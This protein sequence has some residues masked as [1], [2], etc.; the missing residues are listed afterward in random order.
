MTRKIK[1]LIAVLFFLLAAYIL[2]WFKIFDIIQPSLQQSTFNRPSPP[3]QLESE[4]VSILEIDF[5]DGEKLSL[6]Y[7]FEEGKSVYDV[8]SDAL[9]QKGIPLEVQKYD[10]GILVKS[11]AGR[12]NTPQKAW[13][14]FVNGVS[15]DV[16]A[17]QY[18]LRE[19]DQI[20]WKY[21][22]V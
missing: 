15:G 3:T 21:T 8:L 1:I 9:T 20:E 12:N 11:I 18:K 6:P 13:V 10:F 4:K 5:G 19:G 7:K 16:A 22:R 2:G 14:Y 17:D